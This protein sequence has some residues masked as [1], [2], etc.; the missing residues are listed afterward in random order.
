MSVSY[1]LRATSPCYVSYVSHVLCVTIFARHMSSVSHILH[2]TCP[3]RHVS[4]MSHVLCITYPTCQMSCVSQICVNTH[5][6]I[7][8][9]R[10]IPSI[11]NI[12][13]AIPPCHILRVTYTPVSHIL[14]VYLVSP[15][16]PVTYPRLIS[17]TP[18]ELLSFVLHERYLIDHIYQYV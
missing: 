3:L 5:I 12:F 17:F 9:L 7:L 13:R 15:I 16:L 8:S 14:Q 2:V 18:H 11:S 4:C 6:L 1:I 10:H